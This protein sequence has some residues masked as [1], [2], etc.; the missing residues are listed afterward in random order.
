M[1]F[2]NSLSKNYQR[3]KNYILKNSNPSI[4]RFFWR[5]SSFVYFVDF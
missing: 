5:L 1:F 2:K 3:N 4:S